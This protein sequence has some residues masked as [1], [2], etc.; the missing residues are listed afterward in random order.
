[1]L[2]QP[3]G[4]GTEQASIRVRWGLQRTPVGIGNP[5]DAVIIRRRGARLEGFQ[6]GPAA[7]ARA[8]AHTGLG[9]DADQLDAGRD[10]ERYSRLV[11][12]RELQEGAGDRARQMGA[13]GASGRGAP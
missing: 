7:V 12:E 5:D 10:L 11:G 13:G 2:V 1:M 3:A 6:N 8:S 9:V 4:A